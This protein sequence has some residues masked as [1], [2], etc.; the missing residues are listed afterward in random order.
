MTLSQFISQEIDAIVE[1]WAEF[2][3]ENLPPARA[4]APQELRDHARKLLLL[5]SP[6]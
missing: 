5:S 4:L 3:R 1:E 6:F 2:A